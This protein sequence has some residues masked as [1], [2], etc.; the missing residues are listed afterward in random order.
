[1][2]S[3]HDFGKINFLETFVSI[4]VGHIPPVFVIL[5]I[6]QF[7]IFMDYLTIKF[8]EYS[9]QRNCENTITG[10]HTV[11][12]NAGIICEYVEW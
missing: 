7:S 8:G 3:T 11:V 6:I 1:M 5:Y 9:Y 2:L 4:N 10:Q 12:T